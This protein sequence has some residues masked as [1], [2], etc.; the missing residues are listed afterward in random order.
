EPVT[1]VVLRGGEQIR[2]GDTVLEVQTTDPPAPD[3]IVTRGLPAPV[4]TTPSMLE[5]IKLRRSVNRATILAGTAF[6]GALV[7]GMGFLTGLIGGGE[8]TD[9]RVA[10]IVAGAEPSTV[11]VQAQRGTARTGNGTGWVLDA[12]AGLLVTNAHVLNVGD[13]Y[14][15]GVGRTL[16]RASV[17]G[18]SACQ[19][20]A[21]LRVA[22]TSGLRTLPLGSQGNLRL[23]Q[24]VVAVGFPGN[25][26]LSDSLT[27]TV[28]VVS[29][30][31][32]EYREP[33]LDVPH[34]D[35]VLQTDAA[36]NPGNSGGPL[37]TLDGRLVGVNSAGRTLNA[38][39][40]IIQ[41]QSY[42]IG[43]DRVREVV[44]QLRAG[45][46]DGWWGLGFRYLSADDLR[47]RD[48]PA[49]LLIN[50]VVDGSPAQ[51]A[52]IEP[53]RLL[54]T[55][56]DGRPVS[57]SL[58]GYCDAVSQVPPGASVRLSAVNV[59]TGTRQTLTLG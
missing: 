56:V 3:E 15:V 57:N 52:G 37:L 22:D 14:T 43:V 36:I 34:L 39:G 12:R 46:S 10:S 40:R 24:T 59:R 11:L 21:V 1:C 28:G 49:G 8:D 7:V 17:V 25:A 53:G 47:D 6:L 42:A 48:L 51:R 18:V 35:N 44:N 30:V 2:I 4:V 27:S 45:Q 29:V 54:L 41:G 26:S 9:K 58:A 13:R 23:G 38:S 16:R 5:R 55:A 32:S 19:D 50:T 20:L 31:R 33:A